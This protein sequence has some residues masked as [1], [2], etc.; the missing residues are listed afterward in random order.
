MKLYSFLDLLKHGIVENDYGLYKINND[1]AV[2]F[3]R[4][5][6]KRALKVV[7]FQY[8]EIIHAVYTEMSA[9]SELHSDTHR[10]YEVYKLV[11]FDEKS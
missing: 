8:S 4:G 2:R 9:A 5:D 7:S 11:P 10:V 6:N 1:F 3:N